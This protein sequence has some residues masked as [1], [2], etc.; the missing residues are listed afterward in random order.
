MLFFKHQSNRT[1]EI[2][3]DSAV[4]KESL[5]DNHIR[6]IISCHNSNMFYNPYNSSIDEIRIINSAFVN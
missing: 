6:L 4:L 2:K 1:P 3:I 5:Y